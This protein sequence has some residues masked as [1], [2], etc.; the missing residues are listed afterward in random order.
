[1]VRPAHAVRDNFGIEGFFLMYFQVRHII[2]WPRTPGV[3]PRVVDFEL[4][5]VNIISGGSKTGKSAIIPIIDYCLGADRCAIPVETIRNACSWFGIVVVTSEGQKLFARREPGDQK[6]TG[7]MYLLEQKVVTIPS[8]APTKNITADA[9]KARLDEL[10]GLS[11][12]DFRSEE[13]GRGFRARPSFRDLVAFTFQPQNIVANPDVLFFKAD[14]YEHREKL[15]TI[16]PYV[17]KAVT[18]EMMAAQHELEILSRELARKERELEN[19]R[20]VSERWSAE[21]RSWAVQARELGLLESPIPD[22]AVRDDLLAL[23]LSAVRR[24]DIPTPTSQGIGEAM[25]EIASLQS[26]EAQIDGEL[27][28]LRK[29]HAEMTK[30]LETASKLGEALSVQ[31]DRLSIASWLRSLESQH[32]CPVCSSELDAGS[33]PLNELA[34]SLEAVEGNLQRVKATPASFDREM[35]RVKEEINLAVERLKGVA[36]RRAE[37]ERRSTTAREASYRA[38]EVSR[39][40]GKLDRAVE[41]QQVLGADGNL[42]DEIDALRRRHKQLSDTVSRAGIEAR[43]RRALERVAG[44]AGRILPQLDAERPNDPIELSI[45]DL[46]IKVKGRS[47]EDYL[48]EIGSGAN[49]LAYHLAL[50]LSLQQFFLEDR[51]SP[52]PGILVYDQPSQVYFPRRLAGGRSSE[53]DDP[54]LQD[55]DIEAV[56]KVFIMLVSAVASANGQLQ[57]IVLDHASESVWGDVAGIHHVEEWRG[58][59]KLVPNEWIEM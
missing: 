2:L 30:L 35:V 7:D 19:L 26:E 56:K 34:V 13:D 11:R 37:V 45:T 10:S 12:L 25:Q 38:K 17:L 50:S 44:F 43:R 31:R 20:Q 27:R 3:P 54:Q 18:P 48:W 42:Q 21:L 16:F 49:W 39:F 33:D 51:P 22:N 40:L 24:A 55:E 15:K 29:R 57:V 5:R 41:M 32:V 52:V 14:T 47:R 46:T 36:A 58:G 1:V 53:E 4:A 9:I 28:G 6:S 23:L 59:K 8:E